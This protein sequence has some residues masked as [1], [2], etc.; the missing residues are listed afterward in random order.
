M[1]VPLAQ[2]PGESLNEIVDGKIPANVEGSVAYILKDSND[3]SGQTVKK[4]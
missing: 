2:V 3:K 4:Q 1:A